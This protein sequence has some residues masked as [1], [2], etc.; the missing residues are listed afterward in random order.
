MN[1]VLTG[2]VL[3]LLWGT[4]AVRFPT[5]W[6]DAQQRA[7]WA[8]LF[9][10]AVTKTVTTPGVNALLGKLVPQAQVIPHLLAVVTAFFLLRFLSLITGY[11]ADHP[12][13]ARWQLVLA[14]SELVVLLVLV[15][16]TPGGI[17]TKGA[18]L[19]G[20]ATAPTAAAYWVILNGY[21]G[22]VLALATGLFWRIS[23]PAPAGALRQGLRAIAAGTFLVA[24]YAALKTAVIVAHS[25]GLTIPVD[26]A[27]P[28]ANA[29][30]TIGII[31]CLIG[32]AVPAV[33]KLRA[34]MRTYHSLWA[35]RPLWSVMRRTFPELILF[36]RRR[37]LLEL[38]GVDEVQ[39]RL[40]RRVIE[41]R[42]GMLT[43]RDHL[44]AGTRDEARSHVGDDPALIEA[45]GIAFALS[46]YRSGA[47]PI[48]NGDGWA[49][50]G[51]EIADEVAWLSAVSAAF[52]RREASAFAHH[53]P[54]T[55][56]T[57]PHPAA[58]ATPTA[59]TSPP[60][61]AT[62]TTTA[63]TATA[64]TAAT[65]ATAATGATGATAAAATATATTNA[66]GGS[67]NLDETKTPANGRRCQ[68]EERN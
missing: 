15:A 11:D 30:R 54:A 53:Q 51:G 7:M 59:T 4:V 13:A 40:Y 37:A 38:A 3:V 28:A 62:T 55:P 31:V 18:E 52:R 35:L 46:R 1:G 63:A 29:L 56:A 58:T 67:T 21:L 33:G 8:T 6:R 34:I 12:R 50:I 9:A 16:V 60:P 32:A 41:I 14:V 10:L 2:V 47:A 5:L 27:E 44:P 61:T 20:T 17:K 25:A 65:A 42:D 48:E 43:L 36:S 66:T 24:V 26:K 64:R 19:M 49:D 22:A 57:T 68:R 23:R 39:L 45:C